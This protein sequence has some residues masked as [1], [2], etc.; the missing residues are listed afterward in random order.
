MGDAITDLVKPARVTL[1]DRVRRGASVWACL[2][3]LA[4]LADDSEHGLGQTIDVAA[5]QA[6]AMSAA[7]PMTGS[8]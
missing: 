1:R 5:R 2:R 8:A 3:C 6:A 4:D 7:A